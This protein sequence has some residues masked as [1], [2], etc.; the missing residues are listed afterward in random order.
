MNKK[1]KKAE[2][3]QINEVCFD[4]L[5]EDVELILLSEIQNTITLSTGVY[6][7]LGDL[8]NDGILWTRL[9]NQ[10]E[11]EVSINFSESLKSVKAK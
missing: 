8:L 5:A 9:Q 4:Q 3:F 7:L 11:E 2:K 1:D 10:L 6:I